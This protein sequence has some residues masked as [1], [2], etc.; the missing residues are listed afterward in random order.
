M[1]FLANTI[2]YSFWHTWFFPWKYNWNPPQP[3]WPSRLEHLLGNQVVSLIP[4][5]GTC[6][7]FRFGPRWVSTKGNRSISPCL[8]PPSP[9]STT[10]KHALRWG[11]KKRKKNENITEIWST[12]ATNSYTEI[13]CYSHIC[14]HPH[15]YRVKMLRPCG[16]TPLTARKGDH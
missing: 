16:N 12:A 14:C 13:N 15:W 3:A 10:N 11:L 1:D 6:L 8:F 2:V 7:G 5:Q 4:G 9:L